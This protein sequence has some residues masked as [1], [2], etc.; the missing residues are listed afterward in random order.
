MAEEIIQQQKQDQMNG[1]SSIDA[2]TNDH[3]LVNINRVKDLLPATGFDGLTELLDLLEE[4]QVQWLQEGQ[5]DAAQ[6]ENRVLMLDEILQLAEQHLELTIGD[7]II[8]DLLFGVAEISTGANLTEED[9]AILKEQL[10]QDGEQQTVAPASAISKQTHAHI[11]QKINL[12]QD[13]LNQFTELADSKGLS[14]MQ[15]ILLA[16]KD[17]FEWQLEQDKH[18]SVFT[19]NDVTGLEQLTTAVT[20]YFTL[21]N[22]E[23]AVQHLFDGI[24]QLHGDPIVPLED[25]EEFS[26]VLIDEITTQ[27]STDLQS[28]TLAIQETVLDHS[29]EELTEE[30]FKTDTGIPKHLNEF[31]DLLQLSVLQLQVS[32][33][34]MLPLISNNTSNPEQSQ[35][36]SE[37]FESELNKFTGVVGIAGFDGLKQSCE[38]IQ[39]N[40]LALEQ[41]N[42]RLSLEDSQNWSRWI[43]AVV[44]YLQSPL[45]QD[46]IQQLLMTHC[47]PGWLSALNEDNTTELLINLRA[48]STISADSDK[49]QR[50]IEATDEDVSLQLPDDIYPELLD[51]L[52]QELPVLTEQFSNAIQFL[53]QGGHSHDLAIAQRV[54]HTIKGAGNTVGIKGI[55]NLTHHLEDILTALADAETLP[56][57]D[58]LNVLTRAA[59]CL[60]EMSEA[61]TNNVSAPSDGKQVLQEVLDLASR[62]DREGCVFENEQSSTQIL[63]NSAAVETE[64]ESKPVATE[65]SAETLIRVPISIIDKLMQFS[66]EVII[67]N[68]QLRER[69]RQTS[70][71]TRVLQN[72]LDL[73]YTLGLELE[74]LVDIRNY[75]L[76]KG[77]T[78]STV[79]TEFDTLEM[80]QYN[81]LHTCSRRIHEVATDIREI[82][83]SYRTELMDI[84]NMLI[85]QGHLNN[86]SQGDL[87]T[88]RLVPV[89]SVL[90]RIQRSVR[91]SCRLTGKNVDLKISG[92]DVQMDRDILNGIIDPLMHILRNAV[93]HGIETDEN[94]I[95]FGK[96]AD[97]TI[98]LNFRKVGNLIEIQCIDDGAGLNLDAIR[99]KGIDRGMIESDAEIS[100]D[101][102]KQLIFQP[103]FSTSENVTHVSGRGVGMDA[104]STGVRTLGGSLT[105]DSVPGQ[106]CKFKILLPL[107][108]VHYHSLLVK[109][110]TQ[111]VALAE[112]SIEQIL[113]PG[114]GVLERNNDEL[115]F[116]FEDQVY[117]IKT[118]DALLSRVVPDNSIALEK[119]VVI[120]VQQQM[121]RFAILVESIVGV[122][123]LVVKSLGGFVP[124]IHG[125]IGASILDD[126]SIAPVLDVQ[127]LLEE[128]SHWSQMN[129]DQIG[130]G[131]DNGQSYALV[132]DDSLSAR[133]SLEQFVGDLGFKVMAARDGLEAIEMINNRIPDIVITDMEMPR[134]NGIELTEFIRTN[135]DT[136]HTYLP[137]IMI[138]SRSTNKHRLL[139]KA[140]GVDVYLTKPYSEQELTNHVMEQVSFAK[141]P[142]Q[143]IAG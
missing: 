95:A 37:E 1:I 6:S 39:D 114:A 87:L 71:K 85:E 121:S 35:A 38:H 52:L 11:L 47:A 129:L 9:F 45:D 54:A 32:L 65:E 102:L 53:S 25:V 94:R 72:Q 79:T 40:Y 140:K 66:N 62:I 2:L 33:T 60:E 111:S 93:D 97:G 143:G 115:S 126:G 107:S 131:N 4:M 61:L 81:E 10:L 3:C 69:L 120:L 89:Q 51:G 125:V 86:T 23:D 100:E 29:T 57:K 123:E 105:L 116:I 117:P 119:R 18:N 136:S 82:G 36:L 34:N 44:S 99:A 46:L 55:A 132:V 138:T 5:S 20:A 64:A 80:D 49:P 109:V 28:P 96:E 73:I 106:G 16:L 88:M 130:I 43:E 128:S 24:A 108:L 8:D 101:E 17:W 21:N 133:R 41:C 27:S 104:V 112:R 12:Y 92:A 134:V 68:G 83:T 141:L 139:A 113:H 58:I 98:H 14:G 75:D 110:G 124:D 142:Q 118:L 84:D 90:P 31:L 30:V 63:D 7:E 135:P 48:L 70:G 50:Q 42:F 15:D 137:V 78:N 91:Q 103:N 19:E 56:G 67:I 127:E 22:I 13:Q 74:E 77:A 76:L 59:D 122:T 26:Q